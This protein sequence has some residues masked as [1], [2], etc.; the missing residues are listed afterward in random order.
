MGAV[1]DQPLDRKDAERLLVRHG[2]VYDRTGRH[3]VYRHPEHSDL[4]IP[5]QFDIDRSGARDVRRAVAIAEARRQGLTPVLVRRTNQSFMPF[6]GEEQFFEAA[7]RRQA[8]ARK[9]RLANRV[10]PEDLPAA[11]VAPM[12]PRTFS[13]AAKPR[14]GM[15]T[16]TPAEW[17][18]AN[19]AEKPQPPS[20]QEAPVPAP[21]TPAPQTPAPEATYSVKVTYETGRKLD[22]IRAILTHRA[23]EAS[24]GLVVAEVSADRVIQL[25]IE[26]GLDKLLASLKPGQVVR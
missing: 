19:E 22:E 13:E 20:P 10:D 2:F 15:V 17:M 12:T 21:V 3:P 16:R 8:D 1:M 14:T 4:L 24:L 11:P 7:E 18:A 25:A 6:E 23:K 26:Q 9:A 5:L